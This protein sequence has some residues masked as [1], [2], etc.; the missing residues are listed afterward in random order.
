MTTEAFSN[1]WSSLSS[2]LGP[3]TEV[4]HWSADHQYQLDGSFVVASVE[5]DGVW[6]DISNPTLPARGV[7]QKTVRRI[8][9]KGVAAGPAR[10][11]LI[12]RVHFLPKRGFRAAFDNWRDYCNGTISRRTMDS[13]VAGGSTYIISIV[14]LMEA[15]VR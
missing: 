13:K 2:R 5:S 10:E 9:L 11:V 15:K 4:F 3:G 12:K 14:R 7:I 8:T 6:I 1:W